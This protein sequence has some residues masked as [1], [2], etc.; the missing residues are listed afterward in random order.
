MAMLGLG[1]IVIPGIFVALILRY[2][3][4]HKNSSYFQRFASLGVP[5]EVLWKH[6][7]AQEE[8]HGGVR[9]S[10]GAVGSEGCGSLNEIVATAILCNYEP[11]S[12]EGLAVVW[13]LCLLLEK[14]GEHHGANST[15]RENS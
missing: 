14:S 8:G 7:L 1:D 15:L 2:D 13:W 3:F 12:D 4:K 5:V 10:Q 11:L 9:G 6:L